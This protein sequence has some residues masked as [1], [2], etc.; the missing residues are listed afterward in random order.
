MR[1]FNTGSFPKL[2]SF[3]L[4][5]MSKW[6]Y[7]ESPTEALK[8]EAPLAA[9]KEKIAKSGSE[10]FTTLIKEL[11]VQNT[12]RSTIEMVPSKTLEAEQVKDELDRLAAIK[13]GMSDADL[14]EVIAKTIELKKIQAA[15]DS[16]ESRATI[17]SLQLSDLKRE[18]AEY[19]IAVSENENDSGV[20]VVRHEM[21]STSGIAYAALGLDISMLPL[22]DIALLPILTRIMKETG[23]GDYDSV[24]L[25]QRIGMYT[26]GVSVEV[27]D[28]PVK[29]TGVA[30]NVISDC[31]A[32]LTK[33][34]IRGKATSENMDELFSLFKLILT[35]A[36]LDSQSKVVEMLKEKKA[37]M[38]SSIQGSGH[39]YALGR[40]RARYTAAGYIDEKMGGISHLQTV[41]QLLEQ[42]EQDWPS[43]LARFEKIRSSILEHSAAR[44][45]MFL[46]LTGDAAV[47]NNIQPTVDSFLKVLPGSNN[48]EKF[49]DFYS[50]DHPWAE[51]AHKEMVEQAPMIDEGFVVPTQVSY[52]GKGGRIYDAGEVLSGSATVV[53]RFLRTGY[54]WDHVRVMGGAYGGMCMFAQGSGFFG[55]LS[56]RDPNLAKTLDVYDAAADALMAT[57]DELEKDP[58]ALATA[59]IGAVGDMDGALSAD[60]KGWTAFNRWMIREAAEDR[61]KFRDEV[62][63]TKPSDFRD[64]AERLRNMK[65]PSV[66]VVSSKAAFEAAAKEGKTLTLTEVV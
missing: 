65:N 17:P 35:D 12:H 64:F 43:L 37:R 44:D 45:G 33:L 41:K 58:E 2:L 53:A 34:I 24:A 15:E 39:S 63:N 23:A 18:V 25:S 4:G 49:P 7:D 52:V 5:S 22:E 50:Q 10:V 27:M 61:Q 32:M 14:D 16:P 19:P 51:A 11:L 60:Q 59:I 48:G 47:L 36:K 30:G 57:A 3:M 46:D 1:E 28:T 9:L 13:A 55:F 40:M 31:D 26:G 6:I 42:A 29:R 54:L 62:L 38:E 21:G 8:F 66:A 20:T 56:Y